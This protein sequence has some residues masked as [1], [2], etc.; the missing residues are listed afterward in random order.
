MKTI[1]INEI[2][3]F[4][5][6]LAALLASFSGFAQSSPKKDLTA[7]DYHLWSSP[8]SAKLSA[9]G[10][11]ASFLLSYK[12]SRDTLFVKNSKGTKTYSFPEASTGEFSG[13]NWFFCLTPKGELKI[14]SLSG[15]KEEILKGVEKYELSA[16]AKDLIILRKGTDGKKQLELRNLASNTSTVLGDIDIYSYC[17]K[18]NALAYTTKS[19]HTAAIAL[20][21]LRSGV[22]TAIDRTTGSCSYS[23]IVWQENGA[24][25]AFLK[26]SLDAAKKTIQNSVGY[27]TIHEGKLAVFNPALQH[28]FSRGMEISSASTA[29]LS[30]SNDGKRIFFKI[31]KTAVPAASSQV[32]IWNTQDKALYPAK[33][34]IDGW[35]RLPKTAVWRP[36]EHRFSFIT[37]N[38]FPKMMLSGDQKYAFLFNPLQNEPQTNRDAPLDIYIMDLETGERKLVLKSQKTGGG[39]AISV[40]EKHLVYF[41]DRNWWAYDIRSGLHKNLTKGLS[42][43]FSDRESDWPEESS[44]FGNPGWTAQ[45]KMLFIY[46]KYDIWN[47]SLDGSKAFRLTHGRENKTAHRILVQSKD[48]SKKMNYDGSYK[49]IFKPN[50]RL[51]IKTEALEH[52][53]YCFWDRKNGLQP[54]V[55]KKMNTSQFVVSEKNDAY[56]YVEENFNAPPRIM[57]KE[58]RNSKEKILFQSNTQHFKYNWGTSRLITY[59]NSKGTVL[60]GVLCYPADYPADKKYPMVVYVYEKLSKELYNYVNPSQ[61]NET[62]FNIANFTSKGYFVL[63]PDIA[64]EIGNPGPSAADCVVSAVKKIIDS[65]AID[66]TRI[67]LIGHSWGGYETDY[68]ITQTNMFAAAVAGAAITNYVS[69]YLWMI[70]DIDK[71]NFYHAEYG[72]LRIGKSLYEDYAAYLRNSPIYHADKVNTPLLSWAG[73]QDSQV[74]HHQSLE[75]YLALRRLGKTNTMLL[76]PKEDHTLSDPLHKQHLTQSIEQWFDHYL[77]GDKKP[78]S[79]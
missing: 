63:L 54:L 56:A 62:G 15:A 47:I 5:I 20:I 72:Q 19:E 27:Y 70:P 68:I 53:G 2:R 16:D 64:Y 11:W 42:V 6:A 13:D 26:Q 1:I 74:S 44:P 57:I 45:D 38:E 58:N 7:A 78:D 12:D 17:P 10:K 66:S 39:T 35:K 67:G 59:A 14:T 75:F 43:S 52:T 41:K 4:V 36:Q 33:I 79:F 46:D 25:V 65:E 73:E 9:S 51:L 50:D 18:I 28:D 76:Y 24:S 71:P 21:N 22:R 49:G 8:W 3:T 77:K 34:Q 29:N 60:N 69:S 31:K 30:I 37:D 61:N 40:Y 48:Q 32:Q 55:D 23:N